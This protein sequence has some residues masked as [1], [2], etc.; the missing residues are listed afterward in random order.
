MKNKKTIWIILG[1]ILAIIIVGSLNNQ[2]LQNDN[3][4]KNTNNE[5]ANTPVFNQDESNENNETKK[6]E[7]IPTCDGTSITSDCEV[8]G[9]IYSIYKYYP[10]EEEKY[11]YETVTTY[12]RKITGYCTLC[13]D[14]TYSPTCATG[15]GACSHHGGVK[16]WNSPV[17]SE[18]PKKEQKKVIDSPASPERW[19]KV[20]KE[21]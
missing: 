8:D 11:H 21:D 20:V 7:E 19:E 14:G 17:Y 5:D 3:N 15:R 1:V 18:V 10:P 12:E 4:I 2:T 16:E 9:I 6:E 13:N